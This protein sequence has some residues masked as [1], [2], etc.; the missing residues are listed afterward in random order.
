MLPEG[1]FLRK[2]EGGAGERRRKK[3]FMWDVCFSLRL[4]VSH[5]GWKDDYG[6]IH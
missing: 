5:F 4:E 2:E 3:Y 6:R 1:V